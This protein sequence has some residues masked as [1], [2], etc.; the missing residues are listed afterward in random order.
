M[1]NDT[2]Q[3]EIKSTDN[4][5]DESSSLNINPVQIDEF[6]EGC[7]TVGDDTFKDVMIFPWSAQGWHWTKCG[8]RHK[9][10]IT[11]KAVQPLIDADCEIVVLGIGVDEM[12]QVTDEA[13]A[14]L[15][16]HHIEVLKENS[17]IAW[18]TFNQLARDNKMVGALIH[19]TC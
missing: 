5:I 10:G 14:L 12:L 9:P 19:S 17:H 15:K 7:I 2:V 4:V 16:R 1:S 8:T 13:L 18:K 11:A 6:E 3:K